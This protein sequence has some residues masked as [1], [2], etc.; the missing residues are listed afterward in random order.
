MY[1]MANSIQKNNKSDRKRMNY[2]EI[3]CPFC[4]KKVDSLSN[5]NFDEVTDNLNCYCEFCGEIYFLPGVYPI[6]GL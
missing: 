1:I 2:E 4:Y 6:I 3:L 5:M